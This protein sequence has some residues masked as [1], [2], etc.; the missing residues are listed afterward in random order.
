VIEKSGNYDRRLKWLVPNS[1][2]S[3]QQKYFAIALAFVASTG[4]GELAAT[5]VRNL[6]AVPDVLGTM[7]RSGAQ[8]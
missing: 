2:Q 4:G 1:R 6:G 3:K 5:T 8:L 7:T